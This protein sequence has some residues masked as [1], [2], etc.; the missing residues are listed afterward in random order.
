MKWNRIFLLWLI[1]FTI[2][3]LK[4]GFGIDEI[5]VVLSPPPISGW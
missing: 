1:G 4:P 5:S 3:V 2:S